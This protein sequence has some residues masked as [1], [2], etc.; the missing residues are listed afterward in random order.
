MRIYAFVSSYPTPYKPYLDTQ[1]ADLLRRGHDLRVFA[2]RSVRD[3]LSEK[4]VAWGLDA[5]TRRFLPDSVGSAA[6]FLPH[7][8]STVVR[9]PGRVRRAAGVA[10]RRHGPPRRRVKAMA[11]MLTL[12]ERPPDLCLVHG[13]RTT[14]FVPWLRAFYDVPVAMYYHGGEPRDAGALPP[15]RVRAAFSAVDVVFTNTRF[16]RR[17]AIGRGCDGGKLAVL[18]VGFDLDDYEPP[19][20][21]RYRRDG[22]LRFI[23]VGR[24]SEGKGH[25]FAIEALR[26]AVDSGLGAVRHTIVGDGPE[27]ERLRR[28][29]R[30]AE[31]TD[32]VAF[33]G[34]LPHADVVRR[35]GESD[36]LVL[37]STTAGTWT[38]T[39]AVVVQEAL[40]MEAVAVTTR[41][42]GVPESIPEAMR[43]FS[44]PPER[45]DALAD[46]MLRLARIS[47][48]DLASAARD[49]RAWVRTNYDIRRLTDA[50]LD[51]AR[52]R[53]ARPARS[54]AKARRSAAAGS[55]T[56]EP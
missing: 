50:L 18:P 39:Q 21:R 34:A 43:P 1:F 5:R 6:R 26:R 41:S 20:P 51:G 47:E 48:H 40:L 9:R 29:T 42:G 22:V 17:E 54:I 38:E 37:P 56:R 27:R 14:L 16:S 44:V 11:R 19:R 33:T 25:R 30:D 31:L 35:L 46:V 2:N 24:L 45:P 15:E 52:A 3:P 10:I 36:A 4:V 55:S 12:P 53:D 49:A 23:S 8:G 7:L 28:R 13:I 32:R